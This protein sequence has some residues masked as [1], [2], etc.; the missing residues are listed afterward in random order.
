MDPCPNPIAG[1]FTLEKIA[2]QSSYYL[3]ISSCDRGDTIM[4]DG[5][6]EMM[7]RYPITELYFA[8]THFGQEGAI[9]LVHG[10]SQWAQVKKLSLYKSRIGEDSF[11]MLVNAIKIH[12]SITQFEIREQECG[13][14]YNACKHL[15][16]LVMTNPRLEKLVL[17]FPSISRE[18]CAKVLSKGLYWRCVK[19]M[20]KIELVLD[21]K[22]IELDGWI[23]IQRQQARFLMN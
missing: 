7:D 9:R 21:G 6:F 5:I 19:R 8:S 18:A 22:N 20:K 3:V 14:Q 11:C 12:P 4:M 15:S 17:L 2:Y 23:E 10:L 13:I 1:F 16:K